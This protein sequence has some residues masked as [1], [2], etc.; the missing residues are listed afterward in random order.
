VKVGG[1]VWIV[2]EQTTWKPTLTSNLRPRLE[3]RT[4]QHSPFTFHF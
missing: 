4:R 1:R 3:I 2:T